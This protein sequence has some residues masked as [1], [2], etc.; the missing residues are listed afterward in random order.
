MDIITHT[1]SGVAIGTVVISYTNRSLKEKIGLLSLSA[2]GGAL[3]DLDAISLWSK[4]DA[5][6]GNFFGLQN[7]GREIYFSKLW[8]SHHGFLHS[9]TAGFT[10]A[11]FLFIVFY[12][13]K[14]G[15]LSASLTAMIKSL[16]SEKIYFLTF[17]FAFS[18]HLIEDMPTPASVW[19]GVNFFWPSDTYIGGTGD[20]WWWNNYDIFLIVVIVILLNSL[21]SFLR[22]LTWIKSRV[23]TTTIFV[24]G[25]TLALIQIKSRNYDFNYQGFTPEFQVMEVRSKEIQKEILGEHTYS[26]MEKLDNNIPL[27]F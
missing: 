21:V 15:F 11:I 24:L 7:T 6:F 17:I 13:F 8:Y 10:I 4:F 23:I 26:I 2:F 22:K 18:I 12:F 25:F 9:I 1:L 14:N 5:Y 16:K 20:I 3:P 19:G 27:N